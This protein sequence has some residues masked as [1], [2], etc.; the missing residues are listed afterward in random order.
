MP[1]TPTLKQADD[2]A[3]GIAARL[4][5]SIE[6]RNGLWYFRHQSWRAGVWHAQGYPSRLK[7]LDAIIQR[8]GSGIRERK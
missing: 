8:M 3:V 6:K 7:A 2:K 4:G 1:R 5:Y